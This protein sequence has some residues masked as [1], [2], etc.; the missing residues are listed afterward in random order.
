MI[1]EIFV[2]FSSNIRYKPGTIVCSLPKDA[3]S[4]EIRRDH[5]KVPERNL[6]K[7]HAHEYYEVIYTP[8]GNIKYYIEGNVHFLEPGDFLLLKKGEMHTIFVEDD[9]PCQ[10]TDIL[11]FPEHLVGPK[12]D[13]LLDFLDDRLPGQN[14]RFPAASIPNDHCRWLMEQ[15]CALN[16]DVGKHACLTA[17]LWQLYRAYPKLKDTQAY[18]D[19][20]ITNVIRYI[21]THLTEPLSI[22]GLCEEF[23]VSRAQLNRKFRNSAGSSIWEYVLTK[24]LLL[25][26]E[27]L[28]KGL[29]PSDAC[30]QSGFSDYSSFYRAYKEQF[31]LSPKEYQHRYCTAK[32][33]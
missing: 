24:R 33:R 26:R 27:L 25:A 1:D 28:R 13:L 17:L 12:T 8:T 18:T 31:G 19:D 6:Y 14:N 4:V 2:L 9:A 32:K 20:L 30:A 11:F 29:A 3:D 15:L 16:S 22:S 23:F 21:N 5:R 7:V 10:R